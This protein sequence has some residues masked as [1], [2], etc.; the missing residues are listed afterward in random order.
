VYLAFSFRKF[1][2][3][4]TYDRDA[5]SLVK[6]G[7]R[8]F[9]IGGFRDKIHNTSFS[10]YLV[11]GSK[12]LGCLLSCIDLDPLRIFA[13]GLHHRFER[14]YLDTTWGLPA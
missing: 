14:I 1:L 2:G 10:S 11:N 6:L 9:A 4:G 8:V 7:K 5:S 12:R 3:Q 13:F